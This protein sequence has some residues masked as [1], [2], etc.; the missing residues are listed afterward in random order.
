MTMFDQ[1]KP[2]YEA[3]GKARGSRVLVYVTGDRR[4]LETQ[5]HPE[6]L[7][8]LIQHLDAI[9]DVDKISLLL[10]SRG[11]HT[12]AAWSVANLIR[13][14]CKTFEVI[15]PAKAHSGATLISL[16]ADNIVMTKQ[17]TLGPIDPSLNGPLNPEI[18]GAPP[19]LR[20]PVSVEAITGYLEFAKEAL[21]ADQANRLSELLLKLSDEVHPLVLG[22]VY[23]SRS[24][25]RMLA[26]RLIG[27]QV[28]DAEK[29]ERVLS[30][31]CSD[32]GSH[33][34]SIYRREAK[35]DLGLKI[36]KPDAELYKKIKQLYDLVASD[37][38]LN[39]PYSP[40]VTLGANQQVS[41]TF[42][43]GLI[44]SVEGGSH[45][46]VSEGQLTRRQM[47][48]AP[49]VVQMAVEDRRT[50]EGWRRDV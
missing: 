37:L 36:E 46:F 25:I 50:F 47:Q 31:L 16:G 27:R 23:R 32:S 43:R 5:I 12:I 19:N 11:G 9:G 39:E 24:Q 6:A 35:D 22:E 44:E 38:Q 21:G 30:F 1:R 3:L 49:Q 42:R 40:D 26:K 13:Q 8:Y 29:V 15:I 28:T 14:F 18:P 45:S 33:D 48:V 4:G 17:A 34:Y 20:A 2:L 10:Y 7:D 41:Y